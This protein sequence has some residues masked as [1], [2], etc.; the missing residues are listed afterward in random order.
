MKSEYINQKHMLTTI[1]KGL[2]VLLCTVPA[3]L[4]VL[5][6]P[7]AADSGYY[8][9]VVE[10]ISE[11]LMPYDDFALGYTPLY[12]FLLVFLKKIFSIGISYEFFL[13][14]HYIFLYIC[15]LMIYRIIG[16]ITENKN[17]AF[18]AS[19]LFI[20]MSHWLEGNAV[21]LEI[22]SVMFGL[23]GLCIIVS[24]YFSVSKFVLAGL[25][26]SLSFLVKQYGLGFFIL[27]LIWLLLLNSNYKL[28]VFMIIGF[29]LPI[30]ICISV[31]GGNFVSILNGSGYGNTISL[32]ITSITIYERFKYL[33]VRISPALLVSLLFFVLFIRKRLIVRQIT[34][35]LIGVI[36][37]L[38]QFAFGT[39]THYY[40]YIIPFVVIIIF[41]VYSN[42][43]RF[44]SI[45]LLFIF[46][47][48]F[49]NFYSTFYNRV[50]K[51]YIK[52]YAIKSKQL[53]LADKL[54]AEIPQNATL[55]IADIG[56]VSQYYLSNRIPP[57]LKKSG[58]TFGIALTPEEHLNQI[59]SADYVLKFS[60]EYNDFGLNTLDVTN[61]LKNKEI[62]RISE[63]VCLYR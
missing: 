16:K 46:V 43:T 19:I 52:S 40:L 3:L 36:G 45:F 49:L 5:Y 34:V 48:F 30:V 54:Q 59:K 21:L 58:Y 50:Y 27:G 37:F 63:E 41:T 61:Q 8:L 28:Y 6:A 33:L 55:Y 24:K 39:F 1:A 38:F 35:F 32:E 13:S 42:I 4:S 47:T 57:N 9:S 14:I 53:E 20:L 62:M 2:L 26:F 25:L 17:N 44:R 60:K 18:Y 15:A 51:I 10:R 31:F 29:V 56:L 22:P 12:F 11:G 7:I 23:W